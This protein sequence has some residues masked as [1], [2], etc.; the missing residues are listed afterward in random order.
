MNAPGARLTQQLGW[1]LILAGMVIAG[2]FGMW[3]LGVALFEDPEIPDLVTLAILG[4]YAGLGCLLVSAALHRL[5]ARRT[6]RYKDI[7]L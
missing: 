5:Q 6:D 3:Q 7:E 2:G 4:L 1:L